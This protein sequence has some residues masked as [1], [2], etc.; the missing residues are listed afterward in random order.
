MNT[1]LILVAIISVTAN[2]IQIFMN[3]KSS[4]IKNLQNRIDLMDKVQ[5][6][7]TKVYDSE[8]KRQNDKITSLQNKIESQDILIS[9]L[10]LIVTKLIGAGCHIDNCAKR[11]PYTIEEIS[12]ITKTKK[13]EESNTKHNK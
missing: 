7:Q 3:K 8:S 10:Q 6:Q 4:D 9:N 5:E 2:V 13:H 12:K 11:N 1:T